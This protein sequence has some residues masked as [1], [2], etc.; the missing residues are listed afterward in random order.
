MTVADL[1]RAVGKLS[2]D[3]E[4]EIRDAT[5]ATSLAE[6]FRLAR[7]AG[8]TFDAIDLIRQEAIG[9][10]PVSPAAVVVATAIVQQ[11]LV[12]L[13]AIVA[14]TVFV[15]RQEVEQARS[16]ISLAFDV[17]EEDAADER[18]PAAY[19][20]LVSLH[21]ATVR[22]LTARARPLPRMIAYAF[23]TSMPVLWTANRLY[24][25]GA[26]YLELVAENAMVHPLFAPAAGR[27]LAR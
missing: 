20:A 16:R 11:A 25:D 27:A 8:A 14:D 23:P 9:A 22:D 17:A 24:G 7:E 15:S 21:A 10:D 2:A 3:A 6:C 18:D 5:F 26:R 12:T 13:G 19:Q 4:S 1:R